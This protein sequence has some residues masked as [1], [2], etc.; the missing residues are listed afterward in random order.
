MPSLKI[1]QAKSSISPARRLLTATRMLLRLLLSA[2][3]PPK[4]AKIIAGKTLDKKTP[5]SVAVEPS[6]AITN[7]VRAMRKIASP[8]LERVWAEKSIRKLRLC[9]KGIGRCGMAV[10]PCSSQPKASSRKGTALPQARALQGQALCIFFVKGIRH[11]CTAQL[12]N[13]VARATRQLCTKSAQ[14]TQKFT[15]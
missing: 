4:S 1:K 7:H 2:N 5:P 15:S 6:S 12:E 11:S 13:C 10:N 9:H 3:V 8:K 14:R